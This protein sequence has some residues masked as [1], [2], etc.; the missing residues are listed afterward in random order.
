MAQHSK[1]RLHREFP[2][3][4]RVIVECDLE[5]CPHCGMPMLFAV[6]QYQVSRK[7][8]KWKE[9]FSRQGQRRD[10]SQEPM[11]KL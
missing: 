7:L 10:K 5:T 8:A 9:V 3:A 1:H 11:D 6:Y 2:E 4:T